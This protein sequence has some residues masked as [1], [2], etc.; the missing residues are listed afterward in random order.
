MAQ[1]FVALRPCLKVSFKHL[2]LNRK[3]APHSMASSRAGSLPQGPYSKCP[4]GNA[5]QTVGASLLA[6]GSAQSADNPK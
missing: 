1:E 6:K 4:I 2:R 3:N 5:F